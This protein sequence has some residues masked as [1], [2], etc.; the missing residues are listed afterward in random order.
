MLCFI[1]FK[2]FTKKSE[3]TMEVKPVVHLGKTILHVHKLPCRLNIL[4]IHVF[5]S[6]LH[7]IFDMIFCYFPIVIK[8]YTTRLRS[9][10]RE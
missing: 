10:Y 2:I 4:R 9:L 8:R 5:M 6:S 3:V 7:I 1:A